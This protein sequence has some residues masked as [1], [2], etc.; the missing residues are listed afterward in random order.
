MN[1]YYL[2]TFVFLKPY[3]WHLFLTMI[4][5][6]LFA[7]ANVYFIPLVRDIAKEISRKHIMYF[8]MQ[9]LNAAVARMTGKQGS[10]ESISQDVFMVRNFGTT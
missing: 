9:M 6:L 1:N 7:T 8:S 3:K 5:V 2:R 4:I 10:W